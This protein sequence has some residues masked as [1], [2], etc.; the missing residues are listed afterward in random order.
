MVSVAA[1]VAVIVFVVITSVVMG[2]A[3]NN[4][5]VLNN[6]ATTSR[7][8]IAPK[9]SDLFSA[10]EASSGEFRQTLGELHSKSASKP[11]SIDTISSAQEEPQVSEV[12]DPALDLF[13]PTPELVVVN[14]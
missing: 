12:V 13:D 2:A 5:S 3:M 7:S 9:Q 8:A 11:Q 14:Q 10:R 4:G 6:M 1:I